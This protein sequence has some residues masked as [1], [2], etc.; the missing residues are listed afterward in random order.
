MHTRCSTGGP[1]SH[2]A[3][4]LLQKISRLP[5]SPSRTLS[6]RHLTAKRTP[7]SVPVLVHIEANAPPGDYWLRAV[8]VKACAGVANDHPEDSTGIVRYD[9]ASTSDPTSV[10]AV[11]A[12]TTCFDEPLESLVPHVKFDVTNIAGTTLEELSVRFTHE[13]LFKWTI[14]SSS[15]VLDW[16]NP[17]LKRVLHN[18]S[19]FPTEYNIVSVDVSTQVRSHNI[20]SSVATTNPSNRKR[21]LRT[22]SGRSW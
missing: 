2:T 15:L 21:P 13:P 11:K 14:N 20:C 12:P 3:R 17:T 10:S 6:T 18:E 22:T 4:P 16:S 9:A 19:V 8:W 1:P 5:F 7:A